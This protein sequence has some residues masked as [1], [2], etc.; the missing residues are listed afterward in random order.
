LI[1]GDFPSVFLK[2]W[3]RNDKTFDNFFK[4]GP[5]ANLGWPPLL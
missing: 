3:P 5:K 4:C 1:F 2:M